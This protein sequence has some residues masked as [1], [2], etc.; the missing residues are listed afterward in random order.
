MEHKTRIRC[1]QDVLS[2][3]CRRAG[4]PGVAVRPEGVRSSQ[5]ERVGQAH[6][7]S[8]EK[9]WEERKVFVCHVSRGTSYCVDN[10]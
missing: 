8:S 2:G 7:I 9:A 6:C 1:T 4:R 5:V 10:A 3:K